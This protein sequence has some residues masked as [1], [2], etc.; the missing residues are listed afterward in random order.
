MPVG[1]PTVLAEVFPDFPHCL[2]RITRRNRQLCVTMTTVI[3]TCF[4]RKYFI[5][6][7]HMYLL[8]YGLLKSLSVTQTVAASVVYR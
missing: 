8:S 6:S 7:F 3:I 4:A 1:K 2:R 5:Y